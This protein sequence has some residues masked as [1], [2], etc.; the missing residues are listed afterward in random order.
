MQPSKP[1]LDDA[2]VVL[3]GV[4]DLDA[5]LVDDVPGAADAGPRTAADLLVR[6]VARGLLGCLLRLLRVL[7]G[8]LGRLL[9][10]RGGDVGAVGGGTCVLGGLFRPVG[11]GARGLGVESRLVGGVAGFLGVPLGTSGRLVGGGRVR[12]GL[13]VVL[14]RAGQRRRSL[15]SGLGGVGRVAEGFL[16]VPAG[17]GRVG[18]GV[19]RVLVG[20]LRVALCLIGEVL[21]GGRLG[22]RVRRVGVGDGLLLV[23]D[24]LGRLPGQHDQARGRVGGDEGRAELDRVVRRLGDPM[25]GRAGGRAARRRDRPA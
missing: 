9:G 1:G 20:D 10:F 15:G 18:G 21:G 14:D 22:L 17:G 8:V 13:T 6:G 12:G 7:Q 19:R 16:G 23:G 5:V 3:S 24:R 25:P 4:G 11:G 2:V